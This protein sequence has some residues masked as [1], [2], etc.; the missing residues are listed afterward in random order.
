MLKATFTAILLAFFV[1]SGFASTPENGKKIEGASRYHFVVNSTSSSITNNF[2]MTTNKEVGFTKLSSAYKS[3]SQ[4]SE[5]GDQALW[6]KSN[7]QLS[8]LGDQALWSKSNSQ[9]SE[10]GDQA[11]WSKSN[12]QLSELGDNA[13]WSK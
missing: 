9:L 7:S 13:L 12:S 11:L 5:L 10:L 6:S 4:L 2:Q 1:Y 8:E 3:N